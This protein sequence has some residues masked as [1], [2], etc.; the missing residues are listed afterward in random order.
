MAVN[1]NES[2]EKNWFDL[3][4]IHVDERGNAHVGMEHF[5]GFLIRYE[6]AIVQGRKAALIGLKNEDRLVSIVTL[7]PAG[8]IIQI[9]DFVSKA[10]LCAFFVFIFNLCVSVCEAWVQGPKEDRSWIP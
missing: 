7:N 1:Q 10:W 5:D 4:V 2:L 6:E 8:K 3:N 9:Q